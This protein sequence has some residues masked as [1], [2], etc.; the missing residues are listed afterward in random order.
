[1]R[2]IWEY[3]TRYITFKIEGDE[4]WFHVKRDLNDDVWQMSMGK[5]VKIKFTKEPRFLQV[6]EYRDIDLRGDDDDDSELFDA[7][8][9]ADPA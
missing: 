8:L 2:A 3:G 6:I 1:M 5:K 4:R 9:Y 7:Y